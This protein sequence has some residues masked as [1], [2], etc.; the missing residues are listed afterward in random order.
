[1]HL[2]FRI[3]LKSRQPQPGAI[4]FWALWEKPLRKYR[5]G[6]VT[7]DNMRIARRMT[8][9]PH[10]QVIQAQAVLSAP[11]EYP[12]IIVAYATSIVQWSNE[13]R[14][15]MQ[16]LWTN[17]HLLK[18][19]LSGREGKT[20][21]EQN[22]AATR[23]LTPLISRGQLNRFHV[24]R[25]YLGKTA[26]TRAMEHGIFEGLLKTLQCQDVAL[27]YRYLAC[28]NAR[29]LDQ[30]LEPVAFLRWVNGT[31]ANEVLAWRL[32]KQTTVASD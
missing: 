13:K 3:D 22:R 27:M 31:A 19:W 16:W 23:K 6:K 26:T 9:M 24:A 5:E 18:T 12:E 21:S 29:R 7:L 32:L 2:T 28:V 1:V 14:A 15:A 30:T 11:D 17:R 10:R 8:D 20:R 25:G 4:F